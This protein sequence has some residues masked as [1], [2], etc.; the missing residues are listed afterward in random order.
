MTADPDRLSRTELARRLTQ[1][2]RYL[3]AARRRADDQAPEQAGPEQGP[4]AVP[5]VF[6]PASELASG[7]TDRHVRDAIRAA[8]GEGSP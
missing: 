3:I 5:I 8:E 4:P 1:R 7:A 6:V 2:E